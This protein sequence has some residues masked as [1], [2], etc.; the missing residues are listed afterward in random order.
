[1]KFPIRTGN[2]IPPRVGPGGDRDP[3]YDPLS[4]GAFLACVRY[5]E[6]AD[7]FLNGMRRKPPSIH[8][9]LNLCVPHGSIFKAEI[10]QPDEYGEKLLVWVEDLEFAAEAKDVGPRWFPPEFFAGSILLTSPGGSIRHNY[11]TSKKV[12]DGNLVARDKRRSHLTFGR[13]ADQNIRLLRIFCDA[14]PGFQIHRRDSARISQDV[15]REYRP[16]ALRPRYDEDAR[17]SFG[18][19]GYSTKGQKSAFR[20]AALHWEAA[21]EL[22][23]KLPDEN[24]TGDGLR[25]RLIWAFD[26]ADRLHRANDN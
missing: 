22:G 13:G 16:K 5:Y 9:V 3:I 14:K 1:M 11:T 25:Q 7:R 26:I 19:A 10:G 2:K 17:A 23:R 21:R 15:H 4:R 24:L 12:L 6:E 20:A 8:S 18:R